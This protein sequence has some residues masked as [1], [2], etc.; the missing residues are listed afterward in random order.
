MDCSARLM[1]ILE[2]MPLEKLTLVLR[3]VEFLK[4]LTDA[5]L[6]KRFVDALLGA[7]RKQLKEME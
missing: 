1:A 7:I 3:F 5:N 2:G 6:D 4:A